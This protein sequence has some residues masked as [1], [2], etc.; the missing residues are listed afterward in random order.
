MKYKL[1]LLCSLF[2][3]CLMSPSLA[4]EKAEGDFLSAAMDKSVDPG[5]DFFSFATGTWMKNN[6]IPA[7]ERGWTVGHLVQEET[8]SRLKGILE[9]ASSS[10]P[11][12]GT[13]KQK[14]G[15]YYAAG[16]D[17]VTIEKL[18]LQPLKK[19]LAKIDA[20]KD[21]KALLEIAMHL[22]SI[23]VGPVFSLFVDQDAMHSDAWALYLWQGGIGLPDRDYYF[24]DDARTENIRKEY[25]KHV[26][27][28]FVLSGITSEKA[29]AFAQKVFEMEKAMADS[30]RKLEDLRDPYLNYNKMSVGDL[31]KVT[32]NIKWAE[33]FAKNGIKNIDSLI[34]GQPEFYKQIEVLLNKYSVADWKVYL[35]WHLL[36]AFADKLSSSFDKEHFYFWRTVMSGVKEQRPRWK[37]IQDVIESDLGE[38]LGQVYVEKY[39]SPATKKRYEKLV[40]DIISAYG[41][42]IKRLDWMSAET[43]QKALEK[44]SAVTKKVGY[45]DKWKDFSK[46]T[47]VHGAY[48]QNA[49][50]ANQFWYNRY[51]QRLGKPVDRTEWNMTPQTY[52]AY[53][54]PS[55]N[56]MVLPAAI[57]IIPGV[58]DSL[59]D[60]AVVYSYAGASTIG[61]EL[62]HG[63][64]DQG[65]QF[66][67]KGNLNNWWLKEDEEKFNKKTDLMVEQFDNYVVLDSMHVN[68]KATLGENIA[69]LGGLVTGLDAFK[70]TK[71]YQEGKLIA[72]LTPEQRFWLGYAYAWLGHKRPE[73]LA[74]QVMTDV[75][76]PEYLR[77]NGPLSN[78]PDF[79]KAFDIKPGSPM[80]RSDEKRVV[81][82]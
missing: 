52:N 14:I 65:R 71:Q 12:S 74:Q 21:K 76:A 8:Y 72:G 13:N 27:N 69:D 66:D 10:K 36:N 37:R 60:D 53:Y 15:D 32:P 34:V 50:A 61:H 39:Y 26:A 58:P 3:I 23:G 42:R 82:W 51:L 18:G 2:T 67:A 4:Q 16:L 7:S 17:T 47:I 1:Y 77:V 75:H 22:Q 62:T 6:P 48:I 80:Y 20:V 64:D 38:L 41:E 28:M 29:N 35:K 40:D 43:K 44:L 57:F 70:K 25:V 78:I 45:P 73:S 5:K 33:L 11:V 68:G 59:L 56:E 54:N 81:I 9:E 63:F 49:I 19:E 55:N 79:Y 30:S 46:L 31:Q 24:R